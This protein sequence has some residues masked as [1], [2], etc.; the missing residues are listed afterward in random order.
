M[1]APVA[2]FPTFITIVAQVLAS[3]FGGLAGVSRLTGGI[4]GVAGTTELV[5][6]LMEFLGCGLRVYLSSCNR[7]RPMVE[8]R[9]VGLN[10]LTFR[11]IS[12][13]SP[14]IKQLIRN[15]SLKPET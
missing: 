3:S 14:P 15:C 11:R 13:F 9:D 12:S 1:F 2:S 8:E 6:G 7:A 4:F 5:M 10:I